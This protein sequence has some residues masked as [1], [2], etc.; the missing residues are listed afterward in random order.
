MALISSQQ[1]I[2]AERPNVV[3]IM[4]DNHSEWTLGCYGNKDIKTPHIDKLAKNGT[5]FTRAFANNA[6]CSPTRASFLTGLMPCQHG[7]HCF[8]QYSAMVGPKAYNTLEE[9]QTIPSILHDAGYTCGMVGKWHLGANMTPQEG[10]SYWITKPYGSS[11][12][13]YDQKVIENGKI[14]VEPKYLTDLWTEHA[15]KF[16]KQNKGKQ[17]PFFLFLPY[18]GPYGLGAAMSEPIKNRHKKFYEAAELPSFPRTKPHPW[19]FNYGKWIGDVSK[20]R[21][22][23]AEISAIDDGVGTVMQTLD[24]LNLTENTIVIF[25]A[26]QGLSGGQSGFWGMG[27]HTRPLTAY[28]WT[29]TI[30]LIFSHPGGAIKKGQRI[31]KMVA[32]YDVY[33]TLLG[34]LNLADK[35]TAKPLQPGRDFS[36]M[37]AGKEIEWEEK[38]FYEFENVR[39]VRTPKWKYIERIHQQPNELF[40]L[41]KDPEELHSIIDNPAYAQIQQQMK[42]ELDA[43]FKKYADPKWDIWHG[44]KTKARL[45]MRDL[46]PNSLVE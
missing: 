27:D 12:G 10:F 37:L 4:T 34:Y 20:M 11:R 41:K 3:I 22:Y 26:D 28:D 36:A 24:D 42:H 1:S 21:K 29:M 17:K 33:P 45:L 16:I 44:G 23:A 39:A 38:M 8:L 6:V 9:F 30:P 31:D 5:L 46:F 14:R 25:T 15:V 35:I 18:N 2:A 19:N 40:D 43:F 13:F 32:N 7:V